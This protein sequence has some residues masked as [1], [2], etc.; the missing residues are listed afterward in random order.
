MSEPEVEER[1][2]ASSRPQLQNNTI[3]EQDP[4]MAQLVAEADGRRRRE[5]L[6]DTFPTV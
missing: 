3:R 5:T 1:A 6:T 4:I 2:G